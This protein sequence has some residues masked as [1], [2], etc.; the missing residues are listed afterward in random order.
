MHVLL[1]GSGGRE[2]SIYQHLCKSPLIS[3]LWI[4]PGNAGQ[5]KEAQILD[6]D[7]FD[8]HQVSE[9]IYKYLIQLLII[10][11][12]VLLSL[13]IKDFLQ[14][15]H[16]NLLVF[17]PNKY[18][19]Q[20]ESSKWFAYNISN[21]LDMPMAETF[22]A[23][24]FK[25]AVDIIENSSLPIVLKL[26]QLASGK[27][28]SIH[29]DKKSAIYKAKRVLGNDSYDDTENKLLVQK[30]LEGTEA[31]VFV[32]C[33]GEEGIFLP[34][35]QDYKRAEDNNKGENTGGMG[36]Y[37]PSSI[38]TEEQLGSI[39]EKIV[40]PIL[41]KF[42]YTG[43]LYIGLM[44]ASKEKDDYSIVEFNVRFGDPEIQAILPLL[45]ENLFSYILWASQK[46]VEI[47]KVK[48]MYNFFYIPYQADK[49]VVNVVIASKGYPQKYNKSILFTLLPK[50]KFHDVQIVY[51][52]TKLKEE[53]DIY[54]S[55]GGRV[56]NIISKQ[57]DIPTAR[58]RVYQYI[59]EFM[60]Q[61]KKV[62]I[63]FHYR[64][65]IAE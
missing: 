38:I 40:Q 61:N 13:G 9:C 51:S 47:S 37:A 15:S 3:K 36:S 33:N 46:E 20:L 27:G 8:F 56:V 54:E 55:I 49:A 65:D 14:E 32:L 50:S 59:D 45:S 30:F 48:S 16:P 39:N 35:A 34:V 18:A 31:S 24:N 5:D 42:R 44:I 21:Q 60:E 12:E 43:V 4:A 63:D 52:G 53:K 57:D 64:K 29:H 62:A 17:G 6:V 1:L 28:V 7:I 41:N 10:G 58:N 11:P 23:K 26:D 19:A 22:S 25:N 2:D